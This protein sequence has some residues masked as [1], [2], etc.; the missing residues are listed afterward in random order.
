[1]PSTKNLHDAFPAREGF[2]CFTD[3]SKL[4]STVV[5][6]ISTFAF[7]KTLKSVEQT[8]IKWRIYPFKLHHDDR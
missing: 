8:S 5:V 7:L 4:I 6:S 3:L 2:D 1:L